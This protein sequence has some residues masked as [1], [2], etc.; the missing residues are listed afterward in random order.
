MINKI[1]VS[2]Y[3]V[4]IDLGCGFLRYKE[5]EGYI[6]IDILDY[7]QEIV[8]DLRS[9]IPLP[10]NSV[11]AI[12]TCHFL[13]HIPFQMVKPLMKEVWR[14]SIPDAEMFIRLPHR[15]NVWANYAGHLS[16]WD[17]EVLKH[18]FWGLNEEK[19]IYQFKILED[20]NKVGDELRGLI[21]IIKSENK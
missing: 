8:W 14:V 19:N 5:K 21:Q 10:D 6:G 1:S 12:F 3:P 13:E 9:G 2:S 16:M 4:K 20:P 7:G 18:L 15:E 11:S 17:G